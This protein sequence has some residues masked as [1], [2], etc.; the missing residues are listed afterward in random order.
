MTQNVSK[1]NV[2]PSQRLHS[3]AQQ[4]LRICFAYRGKKK[5]CDRFA[6]QCKMHSSPLSL[7]ADGMPQNPGLYLIVSV[8]RAGVEGG[9][10]APREID[11]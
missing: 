9:N 8:F 2:A 4:I 10:L 6:I 3:G 11:I 7:S 1:G 5:H